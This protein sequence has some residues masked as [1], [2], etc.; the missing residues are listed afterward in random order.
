VGGIWMA[1][2]TFQ[3]DGPKLMGDVPG[4]FGDA[5][6]NALYLDRAYDTVLSMPARATSTGLEVVDTQGLDNI[7]KGSAGAVAEAGA[8]L[9]LWESGF[10][11]SYGLA[12]LIGTAIL[13]AFLVIRS[14]S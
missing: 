5:S 13:V 6:R 4:P 12:V 10:V 3:E 1:S 11:R 2:S 9:R 7:V 8:S 14:F